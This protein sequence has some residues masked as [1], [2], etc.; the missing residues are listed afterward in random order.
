[1]GT[2]VHIIYCDICRRPTR[3]KTRLY[4]RSTGRPVCRECFEKY[5]YTLGIHL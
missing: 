1:L 2:L 3:R 4:T 5:G